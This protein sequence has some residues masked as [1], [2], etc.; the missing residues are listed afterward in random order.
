MKANLMFVCF[1]GLT[2]ELV[3]LS[4]TDGS[5]GQTDSTYRMCKLEES[6]QVKGQVPQFRAW[7]LSRSEQSSLAWLFV[8]KS[9]LSP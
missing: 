8:G 6:C 7:K 3:P 4:V 2:E 9:D 1:V 5:N